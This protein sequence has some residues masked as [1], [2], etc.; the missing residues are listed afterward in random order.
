MIRREGET[1]FASDIER[2]ANSHPLVVNSAVIKVNE[3]D[4]SNE[5]LK[6]WAVLKDKRTIGH[7]EFHSYLKENLAYF[8]VPKFIEFTRELPKNANEIVQ[9]F[10]LRDKWEK[11]ESK[12]NTYNTKSQQFLD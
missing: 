10:I 3:E 8:M 4:T 7:D 12:E 2:V 9:K 11:K 6:L 1:F 5:V